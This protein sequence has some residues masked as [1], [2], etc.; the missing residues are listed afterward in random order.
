MPHIDAIGLFGLLADAKFAGRIF[1]VSGEDESVLRR[2]TAPRP[3]QS[4]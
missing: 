2:D 4:D 1:I 3:R